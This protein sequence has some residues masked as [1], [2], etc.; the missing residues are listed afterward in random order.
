MFLVGAASGSLQCSSCSHQHCSCS[1]HQGFFSTT[2]VTEGAW[3]ELRAALAD[4]NMIG[5]CYIHDPQ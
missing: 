4:E 5:L 1:R 3:N 2:Q